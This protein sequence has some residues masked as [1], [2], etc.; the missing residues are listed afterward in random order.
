MTFEL[1]LEKQKFF[2]FTFTQELLLNSTKPGII[3]LDEIIQK[4]NIN[5]KDNQILNQVLKQ[6]EL[7]QTSP[8]V[9]QETNSRVDEKETIVEEKISKKQSSSQDE[10]LVKISPLKKVT[11]TLKDANSEQDKLAKIKP[12]HPKKPLTKLIK[13][14]IEQIPEPKLPPHLAY[15]KPIPSKNTNMDLFELNPFLSDPAVKVIT[16]N[17]NE[18]VMVHGSMGT[19]P[20]A[21]T[22]T[23][24][25]I[26][27]I[28]NQ[29][30]KLSKIPIR[31]GI[32]HV[33]VGN[34]N[35]SAIISSVI[36]SKFVLK[37]MNYSD[38]ISS[39]L[40]R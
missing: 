4:R 24:E 12:L 21:L 9:I 8:Q 14:T 27:K 35:F 26:D 29:I 17:P 3:E 32:Y 11:I 16:A 23:K 7:I 31:E 19:R 22:L 28:I 37:K 5:L 38:Y 18:R 34:I 36:G 15:L 33:V 25:D 39:E 40:K 10:G 30:S 6:Q 13:N 20:T 2:L 1:S